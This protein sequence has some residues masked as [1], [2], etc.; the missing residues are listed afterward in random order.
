[1][2]MPCRVELDLRRR[3][4]TEEALDA[5]DADADGIAEDLMKP[6]QEFFPF[7]FENA[8]TALD[9]LGQTGANLA[10]A[11]AALARFAHGDWKP[12]HDLIHNYYAAKADA[13]AEVMAAAPNDDFDVPDRYDD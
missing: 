6:G 11:E 1:M 2:N 4:A 5:L 12:L 10:R 13:K 8:F 7:S 3:D 9:E